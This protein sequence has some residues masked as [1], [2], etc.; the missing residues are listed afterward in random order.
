[1][2]S[3]NN[4]QT[5]LTEEQIEIDKK[6][7]VLQQSFS[8]NYEYIFSNDLAEKTV[9][10]IPSLT[11]DEEML[12]T[13]KGVSHYE[14][15]MLCMLMLLRM[16]KTNVV[17]LSSVPIDSTV[18]DYYLHFLP[19]ITGYHARQRLTLLS[20][21][22]ASRKSLTEKILDRPRL[23][24]RI[25]HSV[26]NPAMAHIACFNVTNFEKELA[27]KLNVPVFGTDPALLHWGSKTGSRV[28]FK[29][30]GIPLPAGFEDLQDEGDI[31]KA[32]IDLKKNNP[33]LKRAVVKMN[34]GFSGEGNAVFNYGDIDVNDSNS[35]SIVTDEL[36]NNLKLVARNVP[37]QL[38]LD[39]FIDMHGIVE[40][41]VEGEKKESPSVQIRVN[42]ASEIAIIS[43]H[44]QIL[45]GES[46][47]VYLGASFPADPAYSKEIAQ[48]GNLVAIELLKEGILG[49]FAVDFLS[50]KNDDKWLHYAI[51]INLRKGGTTH[52]FLMLQFLTEGTYDYNNGVY[53]MPNGEARC[54]F[55]SDNLARHEY[56][57]LTPHDLIDIAVCNNLLYD[58]VKQCGVMFNM[59]GALSQYGKLGVVCIGRNVE[60]AKAYYYKTEHVLNLESIRTA[61]AKI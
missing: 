43:T 8:R 49:R 56:K 2:L 12:K 53:L 58:S 20:C 11:L 9:I 4:T 50:V 3:N 35:T 13:I 31:V 38:F 7:F 17:Y 59:I 6:F 22:D 54:Y 21:Y 18:I 24:E 61:A 1:M 27:V 36:R 42:P 55:A 51:E 15:R 47:Q 5:M 16:P 40:E 57:G 25:L 45:G 10:I 33:S 48:L 41:F 60:E 14:E 34:D 46:G 52:P 23:I 28:I 30:A 26:R 32:L 19:G 29:R 39:K 44:D 37:Y